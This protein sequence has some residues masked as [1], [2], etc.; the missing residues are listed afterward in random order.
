MRIRRIE[1][2]KEREVG[3]ERE[4]GVRADVSR[5]ANSRLCMFMYNNILI[6]DLTFLLSSYL[7]RIK[8]AMSNKSISLSPSHGTTPFTSGT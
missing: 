2:R 6:S 7:P 8:S 4:R 1:K 5:C 3:E